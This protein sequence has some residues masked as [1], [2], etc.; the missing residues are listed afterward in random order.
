MAK[1]D[2]LI[3]CVNNDVEA[4]GDWVTEVERCFNALIA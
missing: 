2:D 4:R 1:E 3:V